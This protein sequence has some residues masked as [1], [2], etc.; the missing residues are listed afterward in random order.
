MAPEL[1]FKKLLAHYWILSA[2]TGS[3]DYSMYTI[4]PSF[5][6]AN[7]LTLRRLHID[8]D[9]NHFSFNSLDFNKCL[10]K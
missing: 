9:Q 1:T 5:S 10:I 6:D 3:F 2:H 7:V 4:R 8:P